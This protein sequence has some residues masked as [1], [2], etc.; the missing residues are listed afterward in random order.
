MLLWP[1][2]VLAAS[3]GLALV[4]W[5]RAAVT[6]PATKVTVVDEKF[7]Q[8]RTITSEHELTIF[9]ELWSRRVV[10]EPGAVL[11]RF[12]KLQIVQNGRSTTWFYD[13]AGLTQALAIHKRPVY[14]LP[15]VADFNALLGVASCPDQSC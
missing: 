3:G 2:L 6:A 4:W 13:P 1:L 5:V 12:Y 11:R 14:L 8:V 9:N 15:S 10:A 7:R